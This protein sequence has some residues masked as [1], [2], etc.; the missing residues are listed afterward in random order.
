TAHHQDDQLETV[1]LQLLR[2][3]GVAG[4][5][6]M[7]EC[8]PFGAGQ[9]LRPLLDLSRARLQSFLSETDLSWVEDSSN[10]AVQYDRNFLRQRIVPL[11]RERWPGAGATISRTARHMAQAQTLLEA[12]A[13]ID[14]AA[15]A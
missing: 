5:A 1:L 14:L 6:A 7:P 8:A 10:V 13:C 12:L 2:G 4:L 15:V 11:L 9:H 3:A